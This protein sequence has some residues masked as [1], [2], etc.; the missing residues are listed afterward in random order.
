MYLAKSFFTFFLKSCS[1]LLKHN[2][3]AVGMIIFAPHR[4]NSNFRLNRQFSFYRYILEEFAEEA[5]K[6]LYMER[7]SCDY[8]MVVGKELREVKV[9]TL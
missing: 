5:R 4:K 7:K 9:L 1:S 3:R 8:D 2:K 6:F